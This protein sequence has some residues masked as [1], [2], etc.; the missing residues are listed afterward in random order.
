MVA[1]F[2]ANQTSGCAPL[3]ILFKDLTTGNPKFWNWDFGNGTLSNAQHPAITYTQPGTY[4]VTLV[5]RNADGTTGIT[6]TNYITVYPSPQPAFTTNFTTG[7]VP[8]TIQF[9]D[10]S[11]TTVGN[12]VSWLWDFGD[13]STSTAQSPSHTYTATGF[14]NISLTVTSSTGCKAISVSNR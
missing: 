1:D 7:C 2:S 12:I 14:Y 4:T 10:R 8:V 9:T 3:S 11:T 6:K 13:G 5:V